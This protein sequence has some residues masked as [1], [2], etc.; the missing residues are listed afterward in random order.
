MPVDSDRDV[1]R[2]FMAGGE[3]REVALLA[4]ASYA[5]AKYD[6]EAHHEA[7]HGKPPTAIEVEHWIRDQSDH[8]LDE[9]QK[10]AV[11]YF[12]EAATAYMADQ[13]EAERQAAVD[14]SILSEVG[15]IRARVEKAT[16][17]KS[18]FWPNVVVGVVASFAFALL[19]ILA[20]LVF[21]KDPSPFAFFKTEPAASPPASSGKPGG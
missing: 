20:S 4:F 3:S 8:R 12:D 1:F 10:T 18:T 7:R 17:F 9:I 11:A 5:E 21:N 13:I 15:L 14:Q 2:R 6:W 16:S 19:I